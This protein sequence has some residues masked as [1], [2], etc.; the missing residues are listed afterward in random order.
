MTRRY[1]TNVL[2]KGAVLGCA[3]VM[4]A[5]VA[6]AFLGR[7]EGGPVSPP[8]P[9]QP[10][11]ERILQFA[12]HPQGGVQIIDAETGDVIKHLARG[13]GGFIRGAM[14]GFARERRKYDLGRDARFHLAGWSNGRLTLEDPATGRMI[15]LTAF[16]TDNAAAFRQ[17]LTATEPKKGDS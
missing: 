15:E 8:P 4:G 10:V 9:G 6:V 11:A 13:E 14:R 3:L 12:D 5:A 1:I 16:G 2:P 17:Y 7:P